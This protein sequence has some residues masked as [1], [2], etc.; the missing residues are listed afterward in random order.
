MAKP[1]AQQCHALSTYFKDKFEEV[2][3][4]A[5]VINRNKAR[6]QFESILMDY[7]PTESRHLIDFYLEHWSAPSLDWFLYNYD[8]VVEEKQA[9]EKS[10]AAAEKR[11]QQTKE[12]LEEWRKRWKK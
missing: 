3:G 10:E 11:R 9:R 12:R 7:S 6:W 1:T 8:K 5:P 2:V 4:Y